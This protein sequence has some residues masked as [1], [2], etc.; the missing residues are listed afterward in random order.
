MF[1]R[2][3]PSRLEERLG[4][5]FRRRELVVL[6]VTHRSHTHESD[7]EGNYERLE[8][9]GD[10]VLGM[11]AAEWLYRLHPE[12]P[13]G[14]LSKRKSF[15]V[16]RQAL[17]RFARELGLGEL[18][19]LGTGEERSGG[20]AKDS[21]LADSLEAV[22]GAVFLDGGFEAA[23]LVVQRLLEHS[24]AE[25]VL[26]HF[27]AKTR[28]QEVAQGRGWELPE[29]RLVEEAGPDHDKTFTVECRLEGE[30]RGRG[31]GRSKK[32]AEQV[33]AA[34]ALTALGAAP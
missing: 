4:Y 23:R 6:A 17:A 10:A 32:V 33:A 24:E 25:Q 12:L 27:D 28:L 15:L 18:L 5:R 13:E 20:R 31:T 29:Y 9:L 16:S 26:P 34:Q 30:P 1:G 22:F 21:L 8:F 11:V 2:R 3:Q 7:A 14:E 19:L